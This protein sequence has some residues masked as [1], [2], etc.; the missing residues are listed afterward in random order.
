[1]IWSR[2]ESEADL[3]KKKIY[4]KWASNNNKKKKLWKRHSCWERRGE[5]AKT[6]KCWR[7]SDLKKKKSGN[8]EANTQSRMHNSRQRTCRESQ[9]VFAPLASCTL[10]LSFTQIDTSASQTLFY[11]CLL[12]YFHEKPA[13]HWCDSLYERAKHYT[14]MIM[15][16]WVYCW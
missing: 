8:T 10:I 4:G 7:K 9:S 12:L 1:M 2:T 11:H 13:C 16:Q 5:K 6:E 3:K 14:Q 15:L